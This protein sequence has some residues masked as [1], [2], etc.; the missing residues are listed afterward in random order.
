[1]A[2][3]PV[4]EAIDDAERRVGDRMDQRLHLSD[5]ARKIEALDSIADSLIRLHA[6]V[7]AIRILFAEYARPPRG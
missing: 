5:S 6:E 4:V 2:R 1:M 3:D 7:K